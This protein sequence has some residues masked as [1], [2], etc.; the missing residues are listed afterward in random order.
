MTRK[1]SINMTP[2]IVGITGGSGSG[3]TFFLQ[4]LIKKVGKENICEI[5]QDNY[6]KPLREQP[7]DENGIVNFDLPESIDEVSLAHD[8][9]KLKQGK[10]FERLEY[11]FNNEQKQPDLLRFEPRPIVILEGLFVFHY[12][13]VARQ[14]DLKLFVQAQDHIKI[15]RRII[16][17]NLERGYDLH[18]VLY[19]YEKHVMP[20]Y[21][22]YIEIHRNEADLVIC[23]NNDFKT[24][25]EVVASFLIQKV[26]Q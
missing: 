16:R 19:R 26:N 18:D 2:F 14:I 22:K 20:S 25:L 11:T 1:R 17:D 4:E 15:K 24:G 9:L 12:P 13:E 23:N 3:K 5:S 7:V 21:Q 6:Y 8:I 10:G